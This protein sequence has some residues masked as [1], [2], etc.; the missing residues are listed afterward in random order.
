MLQSLAVAVEG[1][2]EGL[3]GKVDKVA[4][5]GLSQ[6][7]FTAAEKAKLA[8]LEGSHYRGTFVS[9]EAL[10]SAIPSGLAGDYQVDGARRFGTLN[11]GGSTSTTVSFVIGSGGR[12]MIG[13]AQG[14]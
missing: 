7:N 2:E 14:R 10:E 13:G 4:G 5:Y 12:G 6:E 11:F 8:G 1:V 9:L 3:G